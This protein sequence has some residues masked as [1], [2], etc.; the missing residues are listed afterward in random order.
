MNSGNALEDL[1]RHMGLTQS[2]ILGRTALLDWQPSD[3]QRLNAVAEQMNDAQQRFVERLY[4]HLRRFPG[5]A[6][7][8]S[9]PATLSRL[10]HSQ[11]DYYQRLWHGPYDDDYVASRVRIGLIHQRASIEMKWYLAGY[12]IYLDEMLHTLFPQHEHQALFASLLKVVFFDMTLAIDTYSSAQRQALED[13]EAR[14]ARALR[15]ANDGIWDW[16]IEHDRLYVSE[17]WASMLDLSRDNLGEGSLSWFSRVHPDDLPGLRQAIDAHVSGANALLHHEYRIRRANGDYLWVQARGVA[18]I[19]SSGQRRITGSQ[20][21]ISARKTVE[22]QLRHAA[23]HDP[24]TG[25]GNRLRLDE[26][27]QQCLQQLGKTGAR[28]AALLFVDLDRFKLINDS[29]GHACGDQVLVEVS[30]RLRHCLRPGDHLCR[31]GGD[32]FVVL[33]TDLACADDAEIVAQRMLDCMHTPMHIADQVL[34]VSASIGITAL[35]P[36]NASQ[37]ALQAADLALY[38]AKQAGKAQFA[39]FSAELQVSAHYQLELESALS[40]ALERNEFVLH[41][42]PICRLE[43]GSTRLVGVE[44]LLRWQRG[45]TLVPPLD[46]IPSLEESGEIIRVGDWVLAQACRQVRAWQL[47]GQPHLHCAVNLSSRQ[48]RQDDFVLRLTEIL[49]D[50]GLPPA[51]LVLEITESQLL[52]DSTATLI[53]L[54]AL[55]NL[56]VQLALDDFGTGYSSLGYLKRFPLNILKVDKSFIGGV[57]GDAELSVIS[58]AIIGLGQSLGLEV[59]AEGVESPEHLDFLRGQGCQLAQGYWFSRPCAAHELQV[60]FSR[61]AAGGYLDLAASAGVTAEA[62]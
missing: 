36:H 38:Q 26:L 30:R 31:F 58:R 18:E 51:S 1:M 23:R 4:D 62:E 3:A 11:L 7:L 52:E 17:R 19:D 53:T 37:D 44:A 35:Q 55:A 6:T 48:L 20:T 14:F 21:D 56:G 12:R 49:L 22:Q 33:L 32:E 46:F 28:E 57:P 2:E 45:D 60:Q 54:R 39:R 34:V 40:Q 29:L 42:Q 25:L 24:L 27:L 16:H 8:I 50:S 13:S 10:A 5:P 41:Y 43:Q 59:I 15:G 47:S 9:D 61:L